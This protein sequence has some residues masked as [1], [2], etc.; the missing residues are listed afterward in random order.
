MNW[1]D[2]HY[3]KLYT[4]ETL[5][6]R[7]WGWEARTTFLHLVKSV[8]HSGFIE[9]GRMDP[10]DALVLQ[11]GL[12]SVVVRVG[13]LELVDSGTVEL[14]DKAVLIPKFVEAQEARKS[15]AQKK[16]DERSRN[17]AK[18]RERM[19]PGV[20]G[21]HPNGP[22]SPAQPSPDLPPGK[23]AAPR[24]APKPSAQQAWAETAQSRRVAMRPGL[25]PETLDPVQ[26]NANLKPF[27][28]SIGTVG[29]DLAYVTFLADDWA[30]DRGWP[31]PAFVA[32]IA[33]Y[34]AR[35][36]ATGD[37]PPARPVVAQ[38]ALDPYPEAFR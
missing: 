26:L 21:S 13:L 20:T 2:E 30:R 1:S 12:P 33:K 38:Q 27:I 17:I 7:A 22:S 32:G 36:V 9:T 15:D 4:R 10:V 3:V 14:V 25:I 16:R 8:D 37:T 11:L 34:H 5:T 18:R 35:A 31:W 6:W 19:S 28:A 24:K 23:P 29:L